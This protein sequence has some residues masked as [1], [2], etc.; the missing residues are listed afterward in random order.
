MQGHR[1]PRAYH[2]VSI[3]NEQADITA[4]EVWIPVLVR[5]GSAIAGGHEGVSCQDSFQAVLCPLEAACP[6]SSHPG[7]LPAHTGWR[8]KCCSIVTIVLLILFSEYP[9]IEEREGVKGK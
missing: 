2:D 5:E 1:W 7:E 8:Q 4:G 3:H 6:V 9:S